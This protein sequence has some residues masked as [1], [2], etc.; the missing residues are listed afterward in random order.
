MYQSINPFTNEL[1]K[2][3]SFSS[4]PDIQLSVKAQQEWSSYSISER[5]A[6]LRIVAENIQAKREEFAR[7]ITAEM[8]K[9][10]REAYYE[11]DKTLTAF[12]YYIPNAEQYLAKEFVQTNAS[13]SYISF[14]PLGVILSVMPWNFPFWQVFR[15]AV[16]SLMAGNVTVL[17]HAPNVP[18]CAEAI[19]QL[20]EDERLPK[21]LLVN[22]CLTNDDVAKLIAMPEIA[23][24]T[25][26]GSD[27]TGAI[28]AGL[29]G[30]NIKKC[31]VELGGND[32][33]IVLDD[34]DLDLAIDGA[35]KS[36]SINSGQS[37][38]AAKRFIVTEKNYSLF[39]A[40]LTAAVNSLIVGDPMLEATQIGPIARKDLAEKVHTQIAQT[41]AQG[42][43]A[44]TN[45]TS[46]SAESNFVAPTIL[47]DVTPTMCAFQEEI[48]GPV[49]TVI[50]ANSTEHAIELANN[51]VYGLGASI[52]TAD[53]KAGEE[54]AIQLQSGNVFIN[55]IVK[56]DA[57]LPFGGIKRSGFGRELSAFGLREFVN[58]KTVYIR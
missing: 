17:K 11:I 2:T 37:C 52:W 30:Q 28:I 58:V 36:R 27:T 56:S 39:I 23:G 24:V 45:P 18:Q 53:E 49:W 41:I 19:H 7:L 10:L 22:Y 51:T 44:I 1:L 50:K 5:G 12:D 38:N 54:L 31:V 14:E 32:P 48:F 6:F 55:D 43:K 4:F 3:Y 57:R 9:P 21:N 25:F 40:K 8:G 34:A 33:F 35:I 15:F 16:P 20:F 13:K 42:A 47:T 26:T 46:I 29:A